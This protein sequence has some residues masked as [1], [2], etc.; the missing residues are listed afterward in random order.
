MGVLLPNYPEE[1]VVRGEN[2]PNFK[3]N[4]SEGTSSNVFQ[5][6]QDLHLKQYQHRCHSNTIQNDLRTFHTGPHNTTNTAQNMAQLA[7]SSRTTTPSTAMTG[8][9]TTTKLAN[10]VQYVCIQILHVRS[11]WDTAYMS[12]NP[13][14]RF[15]NQANC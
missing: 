8:T 7:T 10:P 3:I 2:V 14:F 11:H 1:N 6:L 4:T 15:A 12:T 5:I 13:Q 9:K